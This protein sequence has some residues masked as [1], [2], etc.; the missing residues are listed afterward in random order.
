MNLE[1]NKD[2][3]YSYST[4]KGRP[5]G[6]VNT[7]QNSS[8]TGLDKPPHPPLRWLGH[9]RLR[10]LRL[11]DRFVPWQVRHFYYHHESQARLGTRFGIGLA[12]GQLLTLA[13]RATADL[14]GL[15]ITFPLDVIQAG[16]MLA[17]GLRSVAHRISLPRGKL[18]Y[19]ADQPADEVMLLIEGYGRLCMEQEDGRRLTVGLVAPGDLFGEEAL[20]DVPERESTFEAVLNSQ[21][22]VI[23]REEFTRLVNENPTLL[24]SV[25]EHLAQRLLTQQ[26]H[27]VRLAF[28]PLERRLAWILLQ[29]AAATGPLDSTEPTI[30]IYHKDLAAVLGVW[31]ETITATLNR[32][33]NDGLITQHPG[34][35]TLKDIKRLQKMAEDTVS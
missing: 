10:A 24:R 16:A 20:L 14:L 23:R 3:A 13:L 6:T 17:P 19:Q 18:L 2:T 35:I 15:S 33:A 30:P 4:T 8:F 12:L 11:R 9:H 26:R 7:I 25:T 34:H 1:S 27:M 21:I 32:W 5:I 22:D 28:E 29:L 31:R